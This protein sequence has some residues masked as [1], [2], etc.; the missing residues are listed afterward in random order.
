MPCS[1]PTAITNQDLTEKGRACSH[2][3][4]HG[5]QETLRHVILPEQD[6]YEMHAG[7]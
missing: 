3:G 4:R 2:G 7:R 1:L 6:T 5:L